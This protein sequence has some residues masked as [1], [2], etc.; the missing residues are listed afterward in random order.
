MGLSTK[1]GHSSTAN[2]RKQGALLHFQPP[3]RTGCE[4]FEEWALGED[5]SAKGKNKFTG[6]SLFQSKAVLSDWFYL[7]FAAMKR[8][9]LFVAMLF[10]CVATFAQVVHQVGPGQQFISLQDAYDSIPQTIAQPY[11]IHLMP[12]YS[13]V[14]DTLPITFRPKY[15]ASA[16]NSITIMPQVSG[17]VLRPESYLHGEVFVFDSCSH[18]IVDGRVGGIGDTADMKISNTLRWYNTIVFDSASFNTIRYCDIMSVNYDEYDPKMIVL[19]GVGCT[20]NLF[21]GNLIHGADTITPYVLVDAMDESHRNTFDGNYFFNCAETVITTHNDCDDWVISNNHIFGGAYD[22]QFDFL[23]NPYGDG[24][25][26]TGNYFGGTAPYALGDPFGGGQMVSSNFSTTVSNNT[27]ANWRVEVAVPDYV[28]RAGHITGNTIRDMEFFL[29][30]AEFLYAYSTA[31]WNTFTN[32]KLHTVWSQFLRG[33]DEANYNTVGNMTD[34]ANIQIFVPTSQGYSYFDLISGSEEVSHNQV[35]GIFFAMEEEDPTYLPHVRFRSL[36]GRRMYD[37]HVGS[38]TVV[39]SI[40]VQGGLPIDFQGIVAGPYGFTTYGSVQNSTVQNVRMQPLAPIIS[41]FAQFL[42]ISADSVQNCTVRDIVY[43]EEAAGIEGFQ[44]VSDCLVDSLICPS[45]KTSGIKAATVADCHITNIEASTRAYGIFSESGGG[46][47]GAGII[48]HVTIDNIRSEVETYGMKLVLGQGHVRN[49]TIQLLGSNDKI[50]GIWASSNVK[51]HHN[52]IFNLHYDSLVTVRGIYRSGNGYSMIRHNHIH[53]ISTPNGF[54]GIYRINGPAEGSAV[55]SLSNNLI[56]DV[57]CGAGSGVGLYASNFLD[58]PSILISDNVLQNIKIEHLEVFNG[59][60]IFYCF[61]NYTQANGLHG[62]VR[63]NLVRNVWNTDS[64]GTLIGVS[65]C[66]EATNNILDLGIDSNGTPTTNG[67]KLSGI[68]GIFRIGVFDNSVY[69]HGLYETATETKCLKLKSSGLGWNTVIQNNILFNNCS[70]LQPVNGK[71]IAYLSQS[72]QYQFASYNL[73]Y[74]P[75]NGGALA[76]FNNGTTLRYTVAE[77]QAGM[78]GQHHHCYAADPLFV[79]PVGTS[80]TTD[81]SLNAGSIAFG[82]ATPLLD[83]DYDYFHQPRS[84]MPTIGAIEGI[85]QPCVNQM[86][87]SNCG[88]FTSPSGNQ[89]WSAPGVYFDTIP[90]QV[91]CDSIYMVYLTLVPSVETSETVAA[92]NSYTSPSGQYTWTTS[93]TYVDTVQT[94]NGCDSVITIDLTINDVNTAVILNWTTLVS[95]ANGAQYQW[96]NCD[97]AYAEIAGATS[98]L[99]TP[100]YN[101]S[102]AVEV[103]KNGCTD[104]SACMAVS[105]V[106]IEEALSHEILVYPNPSTGQVTVDLGD[107]YQN[108]TIDVYDHLGR[109]EGTYG[110]NNNSKVSLT[111]DGAAGLYHLVVRFD[112]ESYTQRILVH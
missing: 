50:Y 95:Q 73:Y 55:D 63:N 72:T 22:N 53:D 97:S 89:V 47:G 76:S 56:E 98:Q 70:D 40:G 27:F 9:L 65:Y 82:N 7:N 45:H 57:V 41:T 20:D 1:F 87:V 38:E 108:A 91:G 94:L 23:D 60:S 4:R 10:G 62:F 49:N 88:S 51:I 96:L 107:R 28:V 36:V 19:N 46:Y 58:F 71:H 109:L 42:G 103:T 75:G 26:I 25:L 48:E 102:Y 86:S 111:I 83:V 29:G 11:E 85:Y 14:N 64:L 6:G 68:E 18:V 54:E 79:N 61:G 12:G 31:N 17:I 101:G 90:N 105:N 66:E 84:A 80:V 99:F 3:F 52:E 5:E 34:T 39:N 81:M 59:E 112:D 78:S 74:A 15:G 30:P 37:N 33:G 13:V 110:F 44:H 35:G 2:K 21:Q 100:A 8:S 104:T 93:G 106:G 67:A 16:T 92:C 32:I 77:M 24:F 69:L 43:Y